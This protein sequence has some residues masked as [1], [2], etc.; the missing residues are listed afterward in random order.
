MTKKEGKK[1]IK[2]IDT[3]G[4]A[5]SGEGEILVVLINEDNSEEILRQHTYSDWSFSNWDFRDVAINES[6]AFVE[7]YLK[8]KNTNFEHIISQTYFKTNE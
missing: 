7:K 1:S 2:V 3:D 6:Y 5:D 8:D 4:Y